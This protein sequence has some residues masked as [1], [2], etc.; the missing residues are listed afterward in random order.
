MAKE[1][2]NKKRLWVLLSLA[3]ITLAAVLLMF[4]LP[5]IS[6]GP[7]IENGVLDLGGQKSGGTISLDG[8]WDFYWERF[9]TYEEF[10]Q[11]N[12]ESDL[13]VKAPGAWNSYKINGKKTVRLRV[14]HL[15]AQ[16]RKRPFGG[17]AG[18]AHPRIF[19]V[20]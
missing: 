15:C 17:N 10:L 16:G 14:R 6:S 1:K 20:L 19:D 4:L 11:E 7:K 9:L 8:E 2:I 5:D 18:T 13:T 12:P 3:G